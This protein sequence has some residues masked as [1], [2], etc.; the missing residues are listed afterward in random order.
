[1]LWVAIFVAL[2]WLGIAL[3]VV[4]RHSMLGADDCHAGRGRL[5]RQRAG[6]RADNKRL[7]DRVVANVYTVQH[8]AGC[9]NDVKINPALRQAA[10][11]QTDDVVNNR[12]LSG[13]TTGR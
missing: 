10:Q 3:D 8:Q 11:W 2:L 6:S 9:T 7:N 5:A 12:E 1:M 4:G 13:V